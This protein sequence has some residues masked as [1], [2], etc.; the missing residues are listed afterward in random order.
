ML[1]IVYVSNA[2]IYV[3]F[4]ISSIGSITICEKIKKNAYIYVPFLI[5]SIWSIAICEKIKKRK[6]K[7]VIFHKKVEEVC[8]WDENIN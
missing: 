7:V 5:N 4:L 3:H 6:K 8:E 2:Y 1:L